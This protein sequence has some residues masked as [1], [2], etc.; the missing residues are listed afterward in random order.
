MLDEETCRVVCQVNLN[1]KDVQHFK[2]AIKEKYHHNWIIDNLPAAY[3]V[4]TEQ[5][6]TTLYVGF[7]IGYTEGDT[8]YIYN[9]VNIFLDYH[10]VENEGN[11]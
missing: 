4:D 8:Y 9:H 6:S 5:Y 7:P 1:K 10:I 11:R 2:N 3:I